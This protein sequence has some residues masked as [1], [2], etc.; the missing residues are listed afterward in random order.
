[1]TIKADNFYPPGQCEAWLSADR[2]DNNLLIDADEAAA[3]LAAFKKSGFHGATRGYQLMTDN[4]NE[5]FEQADL[6]AG[7]L[8][9]KLNVPVL[10][11][12]SQPDKA[13]LPGFMD[14]AIKAHVEDE[15]QLTL[16][17]A[18]SQGHYPH[19]VSRDEVNQWILELVQA[20]DSKK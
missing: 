18:Q 7:K 5:E 13:S 3:W 17:V 15:G 11:I 9:T 4:L 19:I 20:V 1:M 10:A 12:D 2:N 14:G 16:K 6:A 8:T